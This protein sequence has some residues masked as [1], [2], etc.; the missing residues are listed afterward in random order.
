M[1]TIVTIAMAALFGVLGLQAVSPETAPVMANVP[2]AFQVGDAQLPA[3]KYTIGQA[4]P[5]VL[6]V[7]DV[8]Q[9]AA[10]NIQAVPAKPK[11]AREKGLLVF[12]KYGERYFLRE[13]WKPGMANGA[14]IRKSRAERELMQAAVPERVNV[15]VAAYN[16]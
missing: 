13:V 5:G 11:A 15:W 2:F 14:Q 8:A 16:K 3:G 10:A 4:A 12:H 7:R 1:R 6:W 9:H